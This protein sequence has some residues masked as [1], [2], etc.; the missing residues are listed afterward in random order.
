MTECVTVCFHR[1]RRRR[2]LSW[3]CCVLVRVSAAERL[4]AWFVDLLRFCWSLFCNCS[5]STA[6]TVLLGLVRCIINS[7][8]VVWL[9][10][11]G[12]VPCY[13]IHWCIILRYLIFVQDY[14][15][16]TVSFCIFMSSGS[17]TLLNSKLCN[18][19]LYEVGR[20]FQCITFK[21]KS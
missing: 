21:I 6:S 7:E 20:E 17:L 19:F 16:V 4:S 14:F 10:A 12:S 11:E 5:A 2:A 9:G 1:T 3:F 18:G 8:S 15:I 13:F